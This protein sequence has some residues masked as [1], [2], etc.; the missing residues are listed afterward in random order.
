[1]TKIEKSYLNQSSVHDGRQLQ[2]KVHY[3]NSKDLISIV[4]L[5]GSYT[6]YCT[7]G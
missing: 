7:L 2:E 4:L 6:F 1:M 3:Y 5:S